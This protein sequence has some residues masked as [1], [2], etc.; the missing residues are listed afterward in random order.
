MNYATLYGQQVHNEPDGR[1]ALQ[2]TEAAFWH[3]R[4]V[5]AGKPHDLP[6]L[7]D[8]PALAR[9]IRRTYPKGNHHAR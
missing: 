5:S 9:E 7:T 8:L 6:P 3:S 4:M 1:I 2:N